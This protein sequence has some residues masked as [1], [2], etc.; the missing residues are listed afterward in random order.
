MHLFIGC[1]V[2]KGWYPEGLLS[3]FFVVVLCWILLT[4]QAFFSS[5]KELGLLSSCGL[6]AF[7]CG[8]F[9]C[10]Q[11][12]VLSTW[13]SVVAAPRPSAVT[14]GLSCQEACGIFPD[15][16]SNVCPRPCNGRWILNHWTTTEVPRGGSLKDLEDMKT[17][18]GNS[19]RTCRD[20][21]G[22]DVHLSSHELLH[23]LSW[24][25]VVSR[26]GLLPRSPQNSFS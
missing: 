1:P 17:L 6:W 25:D 7:P 4:V 20:W 8:G 3:F 12:R 19:V 16:G 10:C 24:T 26:G 14:R 18:V 5:C 22:D 13:D 9:F 15:R 2:A 23:L 21:A 11:T